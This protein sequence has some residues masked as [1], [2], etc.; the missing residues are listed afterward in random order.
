MWW[1]RRYR[2]LMRRALITI[3]WVVGFHLVARAVVESFVTDLGDPVT[4]TLAT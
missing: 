3:G 4:G 1:G 2:R